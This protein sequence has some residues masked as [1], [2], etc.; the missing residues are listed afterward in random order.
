MQ[1]CSHV[2]LP[3]RDTLS[4][5]LKQPFIKRVCKYIHGLLMDFNLLNGDSLI[6]MT[7]E[8]M[9]LQC[10]VLH[11]WAHLWEIDYVNTSLVIYKDLAKNLGRR[12]IDI[13]AW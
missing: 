7:S 3:S 8:V 4:M 5:S 1:S 9:K 13:N 10:N 12:F 6:H 2:R 11:P